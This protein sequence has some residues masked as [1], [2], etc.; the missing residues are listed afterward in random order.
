MSTRR[1]EN[2]V[3][4]YTLLE[5][6]EKIE[7]FPSHLLPPNLMSTSLAT[8]PSPTSIPSTSPLIQS[9]VET[10]GEIIEQPTS[11]YVVNFQ[12]Q[13][14]SKPGSDES[15]FAAGAIDCAPG[16]CDF[17]RAKEICSALDT[18]M[19][20][21]ARDNV[22]TVHARDQLLK[23]VNASE[24]ATSWVKTRCNEP[25]P[26]LK[27]TIDFTLYTIS[28]TDNAIWHRSHIS[29]LVNWCILNRCH[30]Q[31]IIQES[32]DIKDAVGEWAYFKERGVRWN[33]GR[34]TNLIKGQKLYLLPGLLKNMETEYL[35]YLDSDVSV[36]QQDV[37]FKELLKLTEEKVPEGKDC[38]VIIQEN[39]CDINGGFFIM[40]KD[41]RT[42]EFVDLWMDVYRKGYNTFVGDQGCFME[43]TLRWANSS[44][45]KSCME[46]VD[47]S[48]SQRNACWARMMNEWGYPTNER[49]FDGICLVGPDVRVQ[50]HDC[51]IK[52]R[53]GDFGMHNHGPTP[54]CRLLNVHI[55]GEPSDFLDSIPERWIFKKPWPCRTWTNG[56][57]SILNCKDKA[58]A[59]SRKVLA[60]TWQ[61]Y[62]EPRGE[63]DKWLG[64]NGGIKEQIWAST[65]PYS[66]KA[67][68]LQ[69]DANI[70]P[71]KS[72]LVQ[73]VVL[74]ITCSNFELE[75]ETAD[76]L[77]SIGMEEE[78][79]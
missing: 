10:T 20:I 67:N 7:T 69:G 17:D 24:K 22:Y 15:Q 41:P 12:N 48:H 43:S 4:Q 9:I 18:C 58:F 30:Y 45:D 79:L 39:G 19:G 78:A 44:Y 38:F 59:G 49:Y 68:I 25:Y 53:K 54:L 71:P 23:V 8:S 60:S 26:L 66:G 21:T 77:K 16:H 75:G 50:F 65:F 40:K 56:T 5:A 6:P 51:G 27:N 70:R 29:S 32:N 34:A 74:S 72:E 62:N 55:Q 37:S 1:V 14:F 3:L 35:M 73:E 63:N 46:D 57:W 31:M 13:I 61:L 11:C 2:K 76:I 36:V 64:Q 28:D 42:F 47:L 33:G 52:Y